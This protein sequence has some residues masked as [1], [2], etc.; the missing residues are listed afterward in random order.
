VFSITNT[1]KDTDFP[2]EPRDF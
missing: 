2:V 1:S